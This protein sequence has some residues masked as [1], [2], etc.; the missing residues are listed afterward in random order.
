MPVCTD[1]CRQPFLLCPGCT[2]TAAAGWP[3]VI[4]ATGCTFDDAA[5]NN[6]LGNRDA[7]AESVVHKCNAPQILFPS[8]SADK[9]CFHTTCHSRRADGDLAHTSTKTEIKNLPQTRARPQSSSRHPPRRYS[10]LLA[11]APPP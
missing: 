2:W 1:D 6:C 3:P 9:A 10:L 11:P 4:T 8:F 7:R 5:D